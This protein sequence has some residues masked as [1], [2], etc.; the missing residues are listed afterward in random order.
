MDR[1][2]RS[3]AEQRR[4]VQDLSQATMDIR[5]QLTETVRDH[6]SLNTAYVDTLD[7]LRHIQAQ[8]QAFLK[9]VRPLLDRWT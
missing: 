3:L 9:E 4:A 2:S 6:Q 7:L 5:H 8:A 1:V